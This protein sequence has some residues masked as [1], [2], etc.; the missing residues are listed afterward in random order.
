MYIIIIIIII[1]I[2]HWLCFGLSNSSRQLETQESQ[3]FQKSQKD[4]L[5][6]KLL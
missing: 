3:E 4:K 2:F 5:A 6:F 1:I